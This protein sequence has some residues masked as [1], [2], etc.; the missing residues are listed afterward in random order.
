MRKDVDVTAATFFLLGA[1][2]WVYQWYKA[3]GRLVGATACPRA[4]RS[5]LPRIPD[6]A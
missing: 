5:F 4:D 2:N 3:D 1:L 6:A